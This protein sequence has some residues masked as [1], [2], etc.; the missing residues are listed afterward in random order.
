VPYPSGHPV[1]P[2]RKGLFDPLHNGRK[3]HP[4]LRFDVK[5]EPIILKAQGAD[6]EH[7]PELRLPEHLVKKSQGPGMT[8]QRFPIV[9][10]GADCIPR[11]LF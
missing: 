7:E 8:E 11:V 4:V 9:D 2:F 10:T 6:C 5:G 1:I 3:L